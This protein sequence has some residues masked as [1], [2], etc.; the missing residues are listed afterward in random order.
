MAMRRHS[1]AV[2]TCMALIDVADGFE[3]RGEVFWRTDVRALCDMPVNVTGWANDILP[4]LTKLAGNFHWSLETGRYTRESPKPAA[5]PAAR[6]P[7]RGALSS[8]CSNRSG[9]PSGIRAP[10]PSSSRSWCY[11][12]IVVPTLGLGSVPQPHR[13]PDA[14][15][16]GPTHRVSFSGSLL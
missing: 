11:R 4:S 14:G 8:A 5:T 7:Q 1:G 10:A 12:A 15:A 2:P 13:R 3:L 16:R 9:A 6:T